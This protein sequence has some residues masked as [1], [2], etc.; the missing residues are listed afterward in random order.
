MEDGALLLHEAGRAAPKRV[1]DAHDGAVLCVAWAPDGASIATGGEDGRV[2][3]WSKGGV[4]RTTLAQLAYPVAGLDW[5]PGGDQL[6]MTAG[7]RLLIKPVMPA[8]ATGLKPVEWK[9]FEAPVRCVAWSRTHHRIVAGSDDGKT[10]VFA[11]ESG[12][13]LHTHVAASRGAPVTAVAWSPSGSHFAVGTGDGVTVHAMHGW[14]LA[15]DAACP[16]RLAH[17][18]P[19]ALA[20]SRDGARLAVARMDGALEVLGI[21]PAAVRDGWFAVALDPRRPDADALVVSDF[22]R[23]PHV[24]EFSS[25]VLRFQ[26]QFGHL[27]VLTAQTAFVYRAPTAPTDPGKTAWAIPTASVHVGHLTQ[28]VL[29]KQAPTHFLLLDAVQGL[30]I[31]SHDGKLVPAPA[32]PKAKRLTSDHIAFDYPWLGLVDNATTPA[33]MLYDLSARDARR[34]TIRHTLAITQIDVNHLAPT[35]P[36]RYRLVAFLDTSR[37][38]YLW[39]REQGIHRL[40]ASVT[41]LAFNA[42]NETLSTVGDGRIQIWAWPFA[43]FVDE[44]LLPHAFDTPTRA[45]AGGGGGGAGEAAVDRV[46]F[47][48]TVCTIRSSRGHLETVSPVSPLP[49]LLV[50]F[51]RGRE[52]DRAIKVCRIGQTPSLWATLAALALDA[53]DLETA[54]VAYANLRDLPKVHY[55]RAVRDKPAAQQRVDLAL[56][57]RRPRDAEAALLAAGQPYDAIR[58]WTRLFQWE[59]AMELAVKHRMHVD[60]VLYLRQQYLQRLGREESDDRF[61]QLAAEIPVDP[62]AIRV[63]MAAEQAH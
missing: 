33:V 30:T 13:T 53:Q 32:V 38:V 48:R 10:R 47:D 31:V 28:L 21:R 34:G 61:L 42:A 51:F 2:K 23:P 37:N 35:T 29:V 17:S 14:A 19:A 49:A 39:N 56:L 40:A 54:E 63:R 6:V 60:T 9:A 16:D 25:P 46:T 45:G 41:R 1:D 36:E 43:A 12:A 5:S 57:M 58:M 59:R 3:L 8:Q 11:A 22:R 62:A 27:V 26:M 44:D 15:T 24:I 20:W 50:G 52:T 7:E 18:S 4:L 55:V